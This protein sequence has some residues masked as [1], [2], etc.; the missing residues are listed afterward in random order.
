MEAPVITDTVSHYT[1]LRKLGAGG[2]GEVYLA[3][4][5]VLNRRVA[6]KFPTQ[7]LSSPSTQAIRRLIQKHRQQR[8][9]ITQTSAPSTRSVKKQVVL[10]RNGVRGRQTLA[11]RIKKQAALSHRVRRLQCKS[12]T[13]LRQLIQVSPIAISR[14]RTSC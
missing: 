5:T 6:I 7:R 9:W 2:M 1:V 3:E 13:L 8:G 11:S 12:R 10:H 4:D 14:P